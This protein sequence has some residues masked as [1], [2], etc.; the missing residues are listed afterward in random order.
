MVEF[1]NC[2]NWAEVF[3]G[4]STFILCGQFPLLGIHEADI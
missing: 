2:S 4:K 1:Q 3:L